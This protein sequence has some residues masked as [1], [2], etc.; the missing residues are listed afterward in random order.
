M[1]DRKSALRKEIRAA[2]RQRSPQELAAASR[3]IRQRILALPAWHAAQV[4]ALFAGQPWEPDVDPLFDLAQQAGKQ[5]VYPR[6]TDSGLVLCPVDSLA[7]LVET[8]RW[9]LREPAASD[10]V[11]PEVPGLLLVPGL[12]FDEAGRRLGRGGGYYDRLLARVPPEA[13][14]GLCFEL[15]ILPEIPTGPHDISVSR[16]ITEA[17]G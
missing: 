4:V 8:P 16:V 13:R 5:V 9:K 17:R 11:A 10:A 3:A 7:A 2:L 6:V 15:Q 1:P 12:A 14:C